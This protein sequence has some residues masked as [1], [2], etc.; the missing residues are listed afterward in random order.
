[1]GSIRSRF[2]CARDDQSVNELPNS[3][4]HSGDLAT[5]LEKTATLIVVHVLGSESPFFLE[6]SSR[7]AT[8]V[9]K[10]THHIE[11]KDNTTGHLL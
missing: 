11:F 1:M 5:A 4:A 9:D 2:Y 7:Q 8:I 3:F 6:S 10:N